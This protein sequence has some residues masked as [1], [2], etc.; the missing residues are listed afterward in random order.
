MQG[1]A[2]MTGDN[3]AKLAIS[4]KRHRWVSERVGFNIESFCKRCHATKTTEVEFTSY[5][6]WQCRHHHYGPF[7]QVG[8]RIAHPYGSDCAMHRCDWCGGEQVVFFPMEV[9]A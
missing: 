9:S 6:R 4:C 7:T 5:Q 3:A 2:G 1:D 8:P